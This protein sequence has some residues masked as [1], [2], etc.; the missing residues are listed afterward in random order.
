MG[1]GQIRTIQDLYSDGV[2]IPIRTL[3]TYNAQRY[4]TDKRDL[5]YGF[6]G[7]ATNVDH[8]LLDPDYSPSKPTQDIC[9]DLIKH[10]VLRDNNLDVIC[11]GQGARRIK[12]D[13]HVTS[14]AMNW[15]KSRDAE[16]GN[17]RETPF[18]L[19]PKFE[20][21]EYNVRHP[22]EFRASGDV[23]PIASITKPPPILTC[24]GI[25]IDIIQ[26]FGVSDRSFWE[27]TLLEAY[28]R[29]LATNCYELHRSLRVNG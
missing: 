29:T 12:A 8:T 11:M 13:S 21:L 9:V 23:T 15:S 1:L 14:W 2:T 27:V 18:A 16:L 19:L 28:V 25:C 6:L 26:D 20:V 4:A 10:S 17:E 22:Q 5:V 7:L 24:S 3:V